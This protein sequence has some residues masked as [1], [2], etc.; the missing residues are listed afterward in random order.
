MIH[1]TFTQKRGSNFTPAAK[2]REYA[3]KNN[4]KCF[5]RYFETIIEIS[6]SGYSYDHYIIQTAGENETVTI[7]LR[8]IYK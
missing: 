4:L 7:F 3:A 6:G 8:L 1:F 5:L 2:I